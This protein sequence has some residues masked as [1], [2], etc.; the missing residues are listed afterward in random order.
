MLVEA[1]I[2][3][4]LMLMMVILG[5][6][7]LYLAYSALA[8]QFVVATSARD[9]ITGGVDVA[10]V[11]TSI[12]Q[13]LR[14]VGLDDGRVNLICVTPALINDCPA[15]PTAGAPV[16]IELGS[17]GDLVLIRVSYPVWVGFHSTTYNVTRIALARNQ[18]FAT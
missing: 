12:R 7:M 5:M 2:G 15:N 13:R 11:E 6:E 4:T 14:A 8:V 17:P 9:L 10:A 18:R 16:A 1:A 3:L